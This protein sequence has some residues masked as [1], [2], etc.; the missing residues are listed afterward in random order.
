MK[1]SFSLLVVFGLAETIFG[2]LF[3]V[4]L[5][6]LVPTLLNWEWS[7]HPYV[8]INGNREVN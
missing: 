2:G 8:F 4:Q 1:F 6:K 7:E 3:L 5:S